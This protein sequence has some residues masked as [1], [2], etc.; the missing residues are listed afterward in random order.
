[1]A[2][3][4]KDKVALARR[5]PGCSGCAT[6]SMLAG[7]LHHYLPRFTPAERIVAVFIA[8]GMTSMVP[9]LLLLIEG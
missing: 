7:P 8:L 5:W 6:R 2:D 3:R 1:M 4:L 9:A